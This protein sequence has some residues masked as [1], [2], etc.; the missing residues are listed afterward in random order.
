MQRRVAQVAIGPS[1]LRNQ[2]AP[3]VVAIA[4]EFFEKNINLIE[5]RKVLETT[6][7]PEYL[8][9]LTLQLQRAFPRG[10]RSW[11]AARKGLNIFFRDSVYNKYLADY[12]DI[13]SNQT[14]N[15]TIL[16]NLEIPLDK[17]VATELT[18]RFDNLPKWTT[19]KRLDSKR[20]QLYQDAALDY[21]DNL[22]L[23][24]IHLDLEFWRSD[25]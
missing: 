1:T 24:R 19:I 13:P 12:L 3:G 9:Q 18:R 6:E 25:R 20:S 10:G 22:G 7:F 17:D 2:G 5:F 23:A 16:R 11:G 15:V 4:R 14:A 8:D 21:A